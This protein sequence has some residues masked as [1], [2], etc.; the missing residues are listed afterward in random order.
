MRQRSPAPCRGRSSPASRVVTG[1]RWATPPP[2]PTCWP[3]SSTR[4]PSASPRR[5]D[6]SRTCA[7]WCGRRSAARRSV[8]SPTR[9]STGARSTSSGSSAAA[10]PRS[11]RSRRRAARPGWCRTP[12]SPRS[13]STPLVGGETLLYLK[14]DS[15][16]GGAIVLTDED[17]RARVIGAALGHLP[18]VPDG[19][20]CACGQRGCLV[21]VA[22]PDVLLARS[23]LARPGGCRG[24]DGRAWRHSSRR[25]R[26]ERSPRRACGRARPARSRARCRSWH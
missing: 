6:G 10:R 8:C 1:G 9:I 26:P 15:G 2:S 18:V 19:T 5:A 7:S 13:P 4:P 3:E 14:A 20:R 12:T 24:V 21:T 22:G 23:D 17:A 16:I 11:P 25:C